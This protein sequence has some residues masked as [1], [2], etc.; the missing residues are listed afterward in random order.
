MYFLLHPK[1]VKLFERTSP[2]ERPASRVEVPG[3]RRGRGGEALRAA[4]GGRVAGDGT[5]SSR[6]VSLTTGVG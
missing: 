2:E 4:G 6:V 1:M 3:N 5:E